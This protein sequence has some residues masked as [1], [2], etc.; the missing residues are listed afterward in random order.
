MM[1]KKGKFDLSEVDD[2]DSNLLTLTKL[3]NIT[4]LPKESEILLQDQIGLIY[5]SV[6]NLRPDILAILIP[7]YTPSH[8]RRINSL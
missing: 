2:D 6:V 3:L 4:N 1:G 7:R 5:K 8:E